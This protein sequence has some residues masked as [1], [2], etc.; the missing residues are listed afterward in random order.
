MSS[1][2]LL[3][4]TKW[5]PPSGC[6]KKWSQPQVD[7]HSL[8]LVTP[9]RSLCCCGSCC[10][11]NSFKK[12]CTANQISHECCWTKGLNGSGHLLKTPDRHQNRKS[13][14]LDQFHFL[15]YRDECK[16]PFHFHCHPSYHD[17]SPAQELEHLTHFSS[18]FPRNL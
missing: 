16:S 3:I 15:K 2:Y 11:S 5:Q 7:C 17:S 18:L 14:A 8:T 1:V 13:V 9:C 12:P 10:Q 4:A 6:Y